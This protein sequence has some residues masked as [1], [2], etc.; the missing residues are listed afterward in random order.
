[1]AKRKGT[2]GQTIISK[3]L[4]RNLKIEK[5]EPHKHPGVNSGD[6]EGYAVSALHVSLVVLLLL[7]IW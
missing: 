7:Q 1:M 3:A 5:H 2:K 6:P 4:H